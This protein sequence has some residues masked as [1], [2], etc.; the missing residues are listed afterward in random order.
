M[1]NIQFETMSLLKRERLLS[2][3]R[4]GGVHIYQIG[5]NEFAGKLD[6]HSPMTFPLFTSE[7]SAQDYGLGGNNTIKI[8]LRKDPTKIFWFAYK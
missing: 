5:T 4:K 3:I 8:T 1:S 7:K 2:K 6:Q